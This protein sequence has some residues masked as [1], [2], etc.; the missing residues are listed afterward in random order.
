MQVRCERWQDY[1]CI[2][3]RLLLNYHLVVLGLLLSIHLGDDGSLLIL[4]LLV[5]LGTSAGLVS[6]GSGSVGG[7]L[8]SLLLLGLLLLL[9]DSLGVLEG[10][11]NGSLVGFVESVVGVFRCS[12]KVL[13]GVG[14]TCER[15]RRE[16]NVRD[17]EMDRREE[18][19][20]GEGRDV[21]SRV[22][23]DEVRLLT[24]VTGRGV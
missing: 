6:V 11:G 1:K 8:S 4:N 2:S 24:G 19:M 23:A 14:V 7:L 12:L 13:S 3:C 10:V 21:I 18:K 20:G 9:L 22:L 15:E 5:N 17:M 16:R